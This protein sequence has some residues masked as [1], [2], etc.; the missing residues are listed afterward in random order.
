LDGLGIGPIASVDDNILAAL[1]PGSNQQIVTTGVNTLFQED[2]NREL[3]FLK[4]DQRRTREITAIE[5]PIKFL[6]DEQSDVQKINTRVLATYSEAYDNYIQR[7]LKVEEATS[8]AKS[9][10]QSFRSKL[11]EQHNLDYKSSELAA[12]RGRIKQNIEVK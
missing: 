2:L 10:T 12:A 3:G 1:L 8:K 6:K 4:E 11:M 7:G 5:N 9:A